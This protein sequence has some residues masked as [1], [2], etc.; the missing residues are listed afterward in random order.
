MPQTTMPPIEEIN[1][2]RHRGNQARQL[3]EEALIDAPNL[4]PL[5]APNPSLP[6]MAAN[7][8]DRSFLDQPLP[9]QPAL[10]IDSRTGQQPTDLPAIDNPANARAIR[11]TTVRP[12]TAAAALPTQQSTCCPTRPRRWRTGTT[13][14][15]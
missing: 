14:T 9:A 3:S 13:T 12:T 15:R 1:T 8:V 5:Q 7:P 11:T 4:D 6:A 2:A 10:T